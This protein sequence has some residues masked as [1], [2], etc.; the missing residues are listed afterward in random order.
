MCSA[1]YYDRPLSSNVLVKDVILY[2]IDIMIITAFRLEISS[3]GRP[4]LFVGGHCYVR[5]LINRSGMT[6]WRC[7]QNRHDCKAVIWTVEETIVKYNFA[8]NH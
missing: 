7:Q 3:D 2:I 5:H 1:H 6:R 8:H 4:L